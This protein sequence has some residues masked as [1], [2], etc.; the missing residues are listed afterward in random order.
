MGLFQ[1]IKDKFNE[2]SDAP[3]MEGEF[4]AEEIRE[5]ST[6]VRRS[7]INIR[8]KD[9]R[10]R[11][12]ENCC[13]QLWEASD[14]IDRATMEYRL[15]TE[16]LTD[17][18]AIENLP[19]DV[20]LS[21][22]KVANRILKL[23]QESHLSS[24]RLGKIS[25]EMYGIMSLYEDRVPEDY[26]KIKENEDYKELVRKDLQKLESEKAVTAYRIRELKLVKKNMR[27]LVGITIGFG[28]LLF[29]LLTIMQFGFGMN[30][31]P[32]LII[33]GCGAGIA[34]VVAFL[35]YTRARIELK[36]LEHYLNTIISSQNTVKIRF[37]NT[38]NVLE[39]E[40]RKYRI[41]VSDELNYYWDAYLEEKR[42]R[43]LIERAN[44]ELGEE[45]GAL[46]KLLKNVQIKDPA[47]WLNQCAALIDPKEMVEIRHDLIAR[48][49]A[50]RK[51]IEYSS[52][53]R[54]M[55]K[56]EINGIV[57]D[58]PE[59]AQEVLDIVSMYDR[60]GTEKALRKKA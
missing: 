22:E 44:S 3:G 29:I 26:K 20:K 50:L 54:D 10:T 53:N 37:V 31:V 5:D 35:K 24:T 18:E 58:Y 23:D 21:I 11:Y 60:H 33:T 41:N 43:A 52:E 48:R 42:A 32:G 2:W 7:S 15:V 59:Y 40:Y 56:D 8:N 12:I 51:R 45:R 17:M 39:Y 30:A 1:W 14:E 9:Q 46:L 4:E 47:V 34:F 55:A 57:K 36:R 49:Q 13:T 6:P 28:L 25:A 16:Y 19:S 38:T 27:S